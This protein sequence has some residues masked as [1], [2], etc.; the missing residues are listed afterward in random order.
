MATLTISSKDKVFKEINLIKT[1]AVGRE[2]GDIILKNPTVSAAH[3]KI[4]KV[5][6]RFIVHDLDSTNGTFINSKQVAVQELRS[7]DV[8]T[9]GRFH[10]KYRNP[11]EESSPVDAFDREDDIGGMTVMV[12]TGQIRNI[13]S[14]STLAKKEAEEKPSKILIHQSSGPPKAFRLEKETTLIGSG[15]NSDIKIS[16]F[17]IGKVAASV[18]KSADGYFI[19]YQGGY[20]KLKMNGN[21]ITNHKLADEDQFSIGSYTFEFRA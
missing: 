7:G 21:K 8:I 5:G 9:I 17:F 16:G 20:S 6:N 13:I 18:T 2:K 14:E 10:L 1:I 15:P 3:V 12:D 4:E 11:D 19:A